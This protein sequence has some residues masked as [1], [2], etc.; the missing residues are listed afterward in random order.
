MIIIGK[1]KSKYKVEAIP[2]VPPI[3]VISKSP[4]FIVKT[5]CCIR[6][7]ESMH[8]KKHQSILYVS[9]SIVGEKV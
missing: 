1:L 8:L 7:Q 4:M 3:I 2:A 5:P 9:Y 6:F